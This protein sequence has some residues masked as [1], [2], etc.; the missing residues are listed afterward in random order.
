MS[1]IETIEGVAT[2]N[3]EIQNE[4]V[5]VNPPDTFLSKHIG[6]VKAKPFTEFID[7]KDPKK[8]NYLVKQSSPSKMVGEPKPFYILHLFSFKTPILNE[9]LINNSS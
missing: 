9:Y 4:S 8:E 2:Y 5:V 3:N 7:P 6:W 1:T